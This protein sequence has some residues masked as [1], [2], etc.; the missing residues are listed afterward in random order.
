[1]RLLLEAPQQDEEVLLPPS[2]EASHLLSM[3]QARELSLV[4][5]VF[6]SVWHTSAGGRQR[7]HG[8][9][10]GSSRNSSRAGKNI[11]GGVALVWATLSPAS[12][13]G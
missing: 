8:T 5:S 10:S 4:A 11:G 2:C 9:G 1:M 7:W 6:E 3:M 12:G 13:S